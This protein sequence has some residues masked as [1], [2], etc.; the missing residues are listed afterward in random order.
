MPELPEVETTRRSLESRL[1]GRRIVGV[2]VRDRRLRWPVPETLPQD[3]IGASV[4]A[5]R[6]RAKYLLLE[7]DRGTVMVHLGMSGSLTVVDADVP[8]VK[9]DHV[10]IQLDDGRIVRYHDP[11]RFGSIHWL[12]PGE[13]A[14]PLLAQLAPE[15]LTVEFDGRYLHA[16]TRARA[17]AIKLVI[18][19]GTLV[20]G[21]G[22]IYASEALHRA[23]INPKTPAR[24]LSRAR[25]DVLAEAI[26]ETL[27]RA[28]EAGGSTLRDYVQADGELGSF[29]NL[30]AVYDRE[31]APCQ[32][33]GCGAAIQRTV[34][35]ARAT[36]FCPS[37]QR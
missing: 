23:R 24:R 5:L 36:Y 35:A 1:L 4:R 15:P 10:D 27:R 17:A 8:A 26:K 9:H 20:T 2:T 6:R 25:C 31:G 21:V 37:C 33:R 28:I 13:D 30:F 11:R 22:N 34:Q 32:T 7:T 12:P 19:N 3:L 18:M 14:H 29:Q 16:V